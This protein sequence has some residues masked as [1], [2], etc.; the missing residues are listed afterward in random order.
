MIRVTA[1]CNLPNNGVQKKSV[2][3]KQQVHFL[4]ILVLLGNYI[5][6]SILHIRARLIL[7]AA[8]ILN[9][10]SSNTELTLGI[11]ITCFHALV[12]NGNHLP[13]SVTPPGSLSTL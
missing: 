4:N 3:H 7:L 8:C 13:G 12:L 6:Y 11:H 9:A 1:F 10:V 2:H 5:D